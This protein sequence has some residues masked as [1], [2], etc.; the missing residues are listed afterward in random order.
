MVLPSG[1]GRWGPV[2]TQEPAGGHR[3]P[4]GLKLSPRRGGENLFHF[5]RFPISRS[6]WGQEMRCGRGGRRGGQ[7][8]AGGEA[9]GGAGGHCGEKGGHNAAEED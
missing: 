3:A 9:G 8:R 2:W 6:L 7:G 4:A 5:G 1:G